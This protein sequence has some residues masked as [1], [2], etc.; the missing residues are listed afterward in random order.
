MSV[1]LTA[2][3]SIPV[4]IVVQRRVHL[5]LDIGEYLVQNIARTGTTMKFTV[6]EISFIPGKTL[7]GN[8]HQLK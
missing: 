5:I 6:K 2:R 7:T 3:Y 8:S 4:K 1:Y